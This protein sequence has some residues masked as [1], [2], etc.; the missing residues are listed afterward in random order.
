[1]SSVTMLKSHEKLNVKI[2][3]LRTLNFKKMDTASYTGKMRGFDE[4]H[5]KHNIIMAVLRKAN[6]HSFVIC[7][8]IKKSIM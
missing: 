1:M 3:C 7:R 4:E 2:K 8:F 6:A 5:L